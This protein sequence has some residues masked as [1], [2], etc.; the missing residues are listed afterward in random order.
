MTDESTDHDTTEPELSLL[1][2]ALA[3]CPR[4]DEGNVD[5]KVLLKVLASKVEVDLDAMRLR[6][7]KQIVNAA[8]KPGATR[9]S[10]ELT[11]FETY[12]YE[13]TRLVRDDNGNIVEQDRALVKMK[14]AE[15]RRARR[16]ASA[17]QVWADR[18]TREAEE[19]SAWVIDQV[20]ADRDAV[21]LSFG[22][23][24]RETGA[25]K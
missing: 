18:K 13:P 25:L 5:E 17:S 22:V 9:P 15:A 21:D 19:Q 4:D 10:G 3:E 11:I 24:I 14:Q 7:A 20:A 23:F 8:A 6:R 1:D 2:Q 12:P 16:H